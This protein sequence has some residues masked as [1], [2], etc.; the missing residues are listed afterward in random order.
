MTEK[1]FKHETV[2]L[3]EAVFLLLQRPDGLYV[4][5]T[6]GRGGHSRLILNGLKDEGRLIGFDKDPQA[7]E[8]GNQLAEEDGRFEIEHDSFASLGEVMK[9]RDEVGKVSGVLVDLGVSSP[10]LDDADRGFSFLKSGP[11]DMRMNPS[12]G[13][14]AADWVNT[15]EESEIARVLWEYGEERFS[16]RIAR[17]IINRRE[18]QPLSDTLELANLISGAVPKKDK[19]KHPATRSFQAIRIH[20]NNELGDLKDLLE[21]SLEVLE[22]GGSLV[23]IS[24]HSLEDRIVKRFMKEQAKG[25]QL[26]KGLPV[27]DDQIAR[28]MKLS[29]KASKPGDEEIKQNPRARSAV[30]RAAVKL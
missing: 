8:V 13:Q 30:L 7:V 23:V 25:K 15:A 14:S 6:F 12:A 19:F 29:C 22:P 16:R 11:L 4:D 28:T 2:L 18:E 1:K 26:P 27:T 9:R 5:G 3:D 17:A 21:Q 24:F 10:Q 20:I